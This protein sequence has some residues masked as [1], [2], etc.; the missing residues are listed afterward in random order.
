MIKAKDMQVFEILEEF[1]KTV[2]RSQ[3]VNYLKEY[4][5]HTPLTYVL[6]FNYCDTIKSLIPEGRPPFN[7]EPDDGPS[8]ASLWQYL[9]VFPNFVQSNQAAQVKPLQREKLF[10]EMLEAIAVE[11]ANMI[12]LAK[13]R[14][15]EKLYPS[16]DIGIVREAFPDLQIQTQQEAKEQSE[17]EKKADILAVI[18]D[19]KEQ[20]KSLQTE[21][22]DLT[23][24]A[25]AYS[26]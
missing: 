21:I 24:E 11:E 16:L 22:K 17:E 3:K 10:I 5:E 14:E 7:D 19:K 8:K 1:D 15:L 18:Q 12:I 6:K 9:N 13:D 20:L 26:E 2:G 25:K 4:R 23:K